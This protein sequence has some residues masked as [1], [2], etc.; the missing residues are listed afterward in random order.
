MNDHD[1]YLKVL[2]EWYCEKG[3][4]LNRENTQIKKSAISFMD[5]LITRD[6]LLSNPAKIDAISKL[7]PLQSKEY[8]KF[9]GQ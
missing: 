2:L 7:Q 6:G 1:T 4:K 5:H 9:T 3:F 8:S